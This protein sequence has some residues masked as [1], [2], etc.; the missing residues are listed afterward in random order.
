VSNPNDEPTEPASAGGAVPAK[1]M[2][3]SDTDRNS[4]IKALGEH[5]AAGRI[6]LDEYGDRTAKVTLTRTAGD[7][8]ALFEDLPAPHP[9][10]SVIPAGSAL[11]DQTHASGALMP[12]ARGQA[13]VGDTRST[14]QKLVAAAAAAS[15]FVA[16]VLFFLTD[17]WYWFLLIP[18]ISAIAGSI[19]GPDWKDPNGGARDARR[20]LRRDM[21]DGRWDRDD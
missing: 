4:A 2:R 14:A 12:P 16:I 20:Q 15:V 18:A 13:P 9:T 17:S 8:D 7:L 5:L 19:W 1:A 21:H 10:L 11:P 3:I 6:T